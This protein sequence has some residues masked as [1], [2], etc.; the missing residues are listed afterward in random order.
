MNGLTRSQDKEA[1]GS[2]VLGVKI[3]RNNQNCQGLPGNS[4]LI[5]GPQGR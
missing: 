4:V 5:V 2:R 1:T 3:G